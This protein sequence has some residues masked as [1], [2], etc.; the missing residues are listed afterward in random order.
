MPVR[1]AIETLRELDER[2]FLDKLA[3]AIHNVTDAVRALGKNG[4]ITVSFKFE[5]LNKPGMVEPLITIETEINEKPP[6]PDPHRALFY[7]DDDGNPT[8]KPQR[9][10]ELG[11]KIADQPAEEGAA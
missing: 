5:P 7:I 11:L 4:A 9:Q 2:R 3:L 6:K 1:P 10:P 8:T